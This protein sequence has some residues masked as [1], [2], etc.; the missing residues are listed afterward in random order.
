[1]E[2][3]VRHLLESVLEHP[4]QVQLQ[5]VEGE[6]VLLLELCVH[7]DDRALLEADDGRVLRAVRTVVSAGAG[8]RKASLDLVDHL[9]APAEEE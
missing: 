3:L 9:S 6:S 1:M 2:A 8:S 7:A 4:E 5:S